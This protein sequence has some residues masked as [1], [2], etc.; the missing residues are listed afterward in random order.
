MTDEIQDT[1]PTVGR[2]PA[3]GVLS[4]HRIQNSERREGRISDAF[5]AAGTETA[6]FLI[7]NCV[8]R[9]IKECRTATLF[10]TSA[11][12]HGNG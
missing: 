2:M 9:R 1:V 5:G 8:V 12:N 11:G 7:E 4:D 3:R 6:A 10:C